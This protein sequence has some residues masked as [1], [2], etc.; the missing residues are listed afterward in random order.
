MRTINSFVLHSDDVIAVLL[1]YDG[2]KAIATVLRDLFLVTNG[3]SSELPKQLPSIL[4]SFTLSIVKD[5]NVLNKIIDLLESDLDLTNE[6]L[7]STKNCALGSSHNICKMLAVSCVF[8]E[9]ETMT[10]F[11]RFIDNRGQLAQVIESLL[12]SNEKLCRTLSL[13]LLQ[14]LK[15]ITGI[16]ARTFVQKT[17]SLRNP[18]SSS[19]NLYNFSD[20]V[21]SENTTYEPSDESN[22]LH[23]R[24]S[25][26]DYCQRDIVLSK[27]GV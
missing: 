7:L 4:T 25:F 20:V 2:G 24:H 19:R 1:W 27:Y 15:L 26:G 11:I 18:R 8:I 12:K 9:I 3:V 17:L 23:I 22:D 6:V 13:G 16:N 14:E 5:A 10:N 21:K